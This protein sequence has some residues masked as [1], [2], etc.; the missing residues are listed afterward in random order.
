[1]KNITTKEFENKVKGWKIYSRGGINMS[2]YTGVPFN[3][4]CG[5]THKYNNIDT[6]PFMD[7][8]GTGQMCLMVKECKYLN[9]VELRGKLNIDRMENLFSCKFEEKKKRYGF[10][11]EDPKIDKEIDIWIEERWN[12]G[13]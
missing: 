1:M 3:C 5:S 7:N 8:H 10:T 9:A 13:G 6:P 2:P 11:L 4:G 12:L